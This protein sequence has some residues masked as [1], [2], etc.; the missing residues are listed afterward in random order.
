MTRQIRKHAREFVALAALVLI[1]LAV[2]FYILG[3][4]RLAVPSWVPFVGKSYYTI[5]AE[6]STAQAVVPGQGQT[7]DIAGVP[8]GD[9]A[10]V[11]LQNGVARV[12][13]QIKKKYAPVYRDARLL[14]RPKTGLKDM[15]IEMDPGTRSAGL[16]VF[17]LGRTWR[18]FAHGR[19]QSL[20]RQPR[21]KDCDRHGVK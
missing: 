2:A 9:L 19:H 17:R 5:N 13:L 1:A 14:L 10:G 21:L 8:V 7:V 18:S 15:I 20:S 4:E 12:K 6:F 16:F 11:K 3:N